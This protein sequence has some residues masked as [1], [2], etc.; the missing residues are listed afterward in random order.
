MV[1]QKQ[2]D[3]Q[4]RKTNIFLER[5]RLGIFCQVFFYNFSYRF[6]IYIERYMLKFIETNNESK[7]D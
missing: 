1:S 6:C 4:F 2:L 7:P 3:S 5:M